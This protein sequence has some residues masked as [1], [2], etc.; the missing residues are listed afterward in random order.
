M[1]SEYD[2]LAADHYEAS[3][4]EI[5][6]R[7][8]DL[9]KLYL[10]GK[11]AGLDTLLVFGWWKGRFD[12]NYPHYEA[13]EALGGAEG[14][15]AAIAEVQRLGGRVLLYSN[16][17]L[18]D[19]KTEFYREHGHDCCQIDIDGNEYREHYQFSNNGTVLR[20]FGYKTFVTGCMATP[21]WHDRLLDT[22]R[23]KLA[24]HP[25]SVFYDRSAAARGCASTKITSM[26][27]GRTKKLSTGSGTWMISAPCWNLT[28]PWLRNLTDVL[29]HPV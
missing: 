6:F 20:K 18:I 7:Y 8:E 3:V 25:D 23:V 5:F 21:E 13:D 22:T 1:G 28:R 11:K 26:A 14:L 27:A 2:R 4:R 12:N 17:K 24:F 16:G 29:L 15:K 19:V 9:P 10:D